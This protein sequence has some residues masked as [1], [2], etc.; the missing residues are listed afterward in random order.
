MQLEGRARSIWPR[1][2][3]YFL[4]AMLLLTLVSRAADA[5]L[6]PVVQCARPL[7]GALSHVVTVTGAAEAEE[8]WPVAAESGL[9]IA[10]VCVRA[11][12]KVEAGEPLALYDQV[13]LQEMLA[14]KQ[15][16]LK[17]LTLQA[18]LEAADAGVG[19]QPE[20]TP[21]PGQS[22]QSTQ[23][24]QAS[25]QKP[26][27]QQQLRNMELDAA[28]REVDRLSQLLYEG[29]ALNAPVAGTVSEVLVAAGDIAAAGAAF[30]ISPAAAGLVV[31][32]AVT[33]EQAKHL[34][35]GME[36]RF[37]LSGES[38]ASA[39]PAVLR[40][41]TPTAAGYEALF[42]LP[43]GYGAIGQSVTITAT[44][45]TAAYNMRVPLGAVVYRGD[46]AGVYRIRTGQ[47]VLGE[48]EYVE[49]VAV[50]VLEADAQ[51]A[52]IEGA[53]VDQDQVVV[54]SNKPVSE[55]DRVRSAS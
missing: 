48:M 37:Q 53:L 52:A 36:A 5:I 27:L 49:F 26:I 30:R 50:T 54:S 47:S 14:E 24:A 10:R 43:E 7:P 3:G 40:S 2:L 29:A 28:Q 23:S 9:S 55:G 17:T 42:A 45:N 46:A 51:Y 34:A 4:A 1:V 20:G 32:T 31:R 41:L 8:Q 33:G 12:Q 15:A 11:G 44:Q 19:A 22:G 16:N 13:R 35:A 18:Q 38:A 6:L 21:P 25:Q 39:Q